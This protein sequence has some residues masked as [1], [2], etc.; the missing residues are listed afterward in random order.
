MILEQVEHLR[1]ALGEP[2]L[3]EVQNYFSAQNFPREEGEVFYFYYQGLGWRSETG[4]PLRDWKL[5]ASRWLW[6]LEH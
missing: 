6:N 1:P 3:E 4:S 2:S 5:A